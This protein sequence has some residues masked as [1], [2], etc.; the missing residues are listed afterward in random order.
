[1]AQEQQHRTTHAPP[2]LPG[3]PAPPHASFGTV[4]KGF[5]VVEWGAVG[6]LAAAGAGLGFFNT[7]LRRRATGMAGAAIGA[8]GGFTIGYQASS[9]RVL[10]LPRGMG[11][12]ADSAWHSSRK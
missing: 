2:Y 12:D 3:S 6:L 4:V 11:T 9:A 10:H 7:T 8:F 1:M 5:R